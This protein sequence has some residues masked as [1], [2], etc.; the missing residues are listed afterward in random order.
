VATFNETRLTPVEIAIAPALAATGLQNPLD[1][2]SAGDNSPMGIQPDNDA[3]IVVR[4]F[5]AESHRNA[6]LNGF[7][8]WSGV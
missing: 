5:T 1:A 4:F 3:G 2:I 6:T 8:D 7:D